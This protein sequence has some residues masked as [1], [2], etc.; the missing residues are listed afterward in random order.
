MVMVTAPKKK[1]KKDGF[2][3]R[4]GTAADNQ[5]KREQAP[6]IT[7]NFLQKSSVTCYI[8]CTLMGRAC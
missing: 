6:A 1:E 2:L 4:T 5:K 7:Y 8:A 3:F